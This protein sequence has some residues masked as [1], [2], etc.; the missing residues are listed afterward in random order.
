MA[1]QRKHED[2]QEAKQH[3]K[4]YDLG[5]GD[6]RGCPFHEDEIATPD[7]AQ[8]D[9]SEA[10]RFAHGVTSTVREQAARHPSR[11]SPDAVHPVCAGV[12]LKGSPLR[13]VREHIVLSRHDRVTR[14]STLCIV[15]LRRL[16]SQRGG[17]VH[18]SF[19]VVL[20]YG[21]SPSSAV[22]KPPSILYHEVEV[23]VLSLIHISE[24]TRL[25]S[26]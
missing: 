15:A 8:G 25:L 12:R 13:V 6:Q 10:G 19:G 9:E 21:I 3:P 16:V 11:A 4:Q 26:I 2:R 23:I 20:E 17:R 7:Q 18:A 14:E 22:C 24:P 5:W 1:I